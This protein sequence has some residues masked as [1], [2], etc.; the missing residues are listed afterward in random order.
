M[1]TGRT[2]SEEA[3]E[4]DYK[5]EAKQDASSPDVSPAK[6]GSNDV[7]RDEEADSPDFRGR[8]GQHDSMDQ[9]E[10]LSDQE[11]P[12]RKLAA[13]GELG[14]AVED[15]GTGSKLNNEKGSGLEKKGTTLVIQSGGQ[16]GGPNYGNRV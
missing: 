10:E 16:N 3:H 9:E 6:G 8:R 1:S 11:S 14:D 12:R 5:M 15:D 13:T 7:S 2:P 4:N